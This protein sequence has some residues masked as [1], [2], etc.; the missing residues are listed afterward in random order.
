MSPIVVDG[1][2][3]AHLGGRGAGTVEALDLKT[4]DVKWKWT[5]DG[6]GYASP[7]LLT[8]EGV[9]QIVTQ[10]DS[11]VVGIGTADGKLLWKLPFAPSGMGYNAASPIVD[12]TTVIF[13]GSARG[14]TAVKVAKTGDTFTATQVWK[15]ATTAT[16]FN[17]PVLKDGFIYGLSDSA[18]LFCVK[19]ATGETAWKDATKRGGNYAAIVDAG[20]VM[21]ALPSNSTLVAFKPDGTAYSELA[22]IKVSSAATYAYPVV[23]GNTMYIRDDTSVSMFVI[24]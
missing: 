19:A 21:L 17:T 9:K 20:S 1:N 8:V 3:I 24:E 14:M 16:Q 13:T 5:G 10:T 18:T 6:P 23:D 7:V 22:Q 4:G 12:G 11:S 2:V 15:N